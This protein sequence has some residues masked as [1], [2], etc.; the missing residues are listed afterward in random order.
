MALSAFPF[1]HTIATSHLFLEKKYQ[2]KNDF[3]Q[4]ILEADL[5]GHFENSDKTIIF[6]TISL[7][8]FIV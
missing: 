8:S 7:N 6:Q 3:I 2:S 5:K 1:P 4:H